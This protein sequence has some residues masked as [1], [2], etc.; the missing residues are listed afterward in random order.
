VTVRALKFDGREHRRWQAELVRCQDS[1]LELVGT[2]EEEINHR[3]LGK[4]ACGT[5]SQE[6]YWLDRWYNVFRFLWPDGALRSYY[7]NV[8]VPPTFDGRRLDFI[9]LDMDILVSPDHT[10]I[11]LDEDEFEINAKLYQYPPDV[12]RG[13]RQ[14]LDELVRLIES[15]QFPFDH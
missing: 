8:N 12:Q 5:V 2:F 10:Y 6:Y 7:C 4:I 11:I 9:D 13:A 3:L 15:R 1:L 14:A